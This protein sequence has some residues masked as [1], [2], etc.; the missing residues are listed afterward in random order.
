MVPAAFTAAVS[1]FLLSLGLIVAI[2]AQNAFVLRQGLRGEHVF[3][4]CATCA[5][6]DALLI[7]LGVTSLTIISAYLPGIEPALRYGGAVFLALYGLRSLFQG[8]RG[9]KALAPA[10]ARPMSLAATLA[11]LLS[12][13][14]LNPHVYLDTVILIGSI[15]SRY[16]GHQPA[17]T[18]GACLGSLVFFFTLGYGAQLLRPIFARPSAWRVLDAIIAVVMFTLALSLVTNGA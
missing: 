14:F 3:W 4:V 8:I 16:P 2:G 6:C 5:L 12:L 15:A 1:G 11:I 18:I 17:F 9:S 13:T 7:I 10:D